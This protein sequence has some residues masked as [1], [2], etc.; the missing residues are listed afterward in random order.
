LTSSFFNRRRPWRRA[1]C[2][3]YPAARA[4]E[5]RAFLRLRVG[6]LQAV[7]WAG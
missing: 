7:A 3:L 2:W 1:V 4:N 6:V 5:G